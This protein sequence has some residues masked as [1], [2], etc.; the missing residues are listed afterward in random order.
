MKLIGTPEF[1]ECLNSFAKVVY[2]SKKRFNVLKQF[3]TSQQFYLKI[4][5]WV[6]MVDSVVPWFELKP[7][8]FL[9]GVCMTIPKCD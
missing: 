8:V 4:R 2:F 1:D 3:Q 9:L 7:G 5:G 6:C